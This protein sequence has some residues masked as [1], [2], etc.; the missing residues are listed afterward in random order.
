MKDEKIVELFLRRDESAL[1]EAEAKY[2]DL[3]HYIA[4]NYLGAREDREECVN[5]TLLALWNSIPP[6]QP[7]SLYAY[8][9]ATV[10]NIALYRSRTNNA[11]KR[12]GQVQVVGEEFLSVI[13]EGRSLSEDYESTRAGEVINAFLEKSGKKERAVFVMRYWH[14]ESIPRIAARTGFSEGKI[15]MML[16]RMRRRLQDELLKEGI[17]V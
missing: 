2:G 12:G 16:M 4:A 11:W 8:I 13:E 10:R 7:R 6:E 17:T 1:R 14:G 9:S 5:D 15:K 3:C